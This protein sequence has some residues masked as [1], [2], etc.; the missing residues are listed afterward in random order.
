MRVQEF[1]DVLRD[2]ERLKKTV[3]HIE[4]IDESDLA[5]AAMGTVTMGFRGQ[6]LTFTGVDYL[7]QFA[8]PNFFFH[9]TTAYDIL[10]QRGLEIGKPDY[11]GPFGSD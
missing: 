2:V 9:V 10:R 7:F 11:L 5:N 1:L 6:D 4:R 3:V 8:L